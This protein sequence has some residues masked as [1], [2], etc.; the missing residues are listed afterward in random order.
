MRNRRIHVLIV[1]FG[2]AVCVIPFHAKVRSAAVSAIQILK[3]KKS[4]AE[5]VAE[6]GDAVHNR[7]AA[8]FKEVGVEYPPKKIILVGFKQERALEVWVANESGE[9]QYLKSYPILAASGTLGPKLAKGDGQVPEGLYRIES[10]N[11]NSLF[12]LALRVDYPNAFDKAKG[13]LDGRANLGSDIM[14]HGKSAS[15]GC[16]AMGDT[17]A[18]DL[19][20]LAA[21]AGIGHIE[22]ILSPV[23]FRKRGLPSN[24]PDVSSWVP[25]LYS[26]IQEELL[27]LTRQQDAAA[28]RSQPIRPP[29]NGTSS[30]AGSRR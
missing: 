15:I 4:V 18:E 2:L 3:G 20:V 24:M 6:F 25:K 23:D 27:K 12:H 29:S 13:T 14:I 17:A 7:L 11:P 5:R 1:L 8:R 26:D 21:E 30:A 16:L 22:V 9:F 10:L 19:F 28:N